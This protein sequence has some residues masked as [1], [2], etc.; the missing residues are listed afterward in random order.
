MQI[1]I[2]IINK[3]CYTPANWLYRQI[4][5]LVFNTLELV[6]TFNVILISK[7]NPTSAPFSPSV[8]NTISLQLLLEV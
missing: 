4:Y 2:H 1:S 7:S 8:V 3:I 5:W 6:L